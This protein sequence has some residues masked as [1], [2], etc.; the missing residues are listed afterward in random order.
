MK[1]N[2]RITILLL[3]MFLLTQIIGLYVVHYYFPTEKTIPFGLEPPQPEKPSDYNW[4]LSS[5]IFSFI[6][7]VLLLFLFTKFK[8]RFILKL[9]FLIVVVLALAVSFLAILPIKT[10]LIA[11]AIAIPLALI[12]LYGKSFVFH[13]ITEFFIYPGI[14]A[15]FVPILSIWTMIALLVLISVY[16]LWAVW[17]SGIMQ[18]MAKYQ[19]EEMGVF[20]GF[21]VPY[22]SK[23]VK[24]QIKK[25]KRI[26][27]KKQLE[28]KKIKINVAILGGGDIVF[29]IITAG[30]MLKTLGLTSAI[31]VI[32]GATLGLAYLFFVAEKKKFYPA[33]PF[34][35]TGIFLGILLSY[36]IL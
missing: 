17:H 35:T 27:S 14:A 7:A 5:I 26:L 4:F 24:Q 9:W 6:I 32:L 15:I 30:V 25:W 21:F 18:R 1:H 10:T 33:M 29:P 22:L 13:N 19:I 2:L 23:K 12:K 34:I 11:L 28:K 8:F 31:L 20:T 36:L 3:V 16:D